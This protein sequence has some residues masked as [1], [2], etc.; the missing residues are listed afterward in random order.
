ML[1]LK[2]ILIGLAILT[3]VAV[4]CF[5]R[6]SC[7]H[8]DTPEQTYQS[9]VIE[10]GERYLKAFKPIPTIP[11]LYRPGYW[12]FDRVLCPPA[13]TNIRAVNWWYLR[14]CTASFWFY[15]HRYE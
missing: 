3:A 1:T 9:W 14:C 12:L 7:V 8:S 15:K 2:D 5:W 11:I 13:D 10:S 4:L 6:V